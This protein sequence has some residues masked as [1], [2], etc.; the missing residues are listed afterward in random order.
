MTIVRWTYQ[1]TAVESDVFFM[2]EVARDGSPTHENDDDDA[3]FTSYILF[4]WR[5]D[6]PVSDKL[7]L[8]DW[9]YVNPTE[10]RHG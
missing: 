7:P 8:R 6:G 5:V 9:F 2:V 4:L 1:T 10:L 3:C